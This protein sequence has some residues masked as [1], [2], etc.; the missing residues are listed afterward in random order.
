MAN[1]NLEPGNAT[2][3]DMIAAIDHGI[4]MRTNCSWSIDDSR[5]KFQFG[6]EWGQL[7]AGG[8]LTTVVKNPN[9]RHLATFWRSLKMVGNRDT[10]DIMGTRV[11]QGTESGH[12]HGTCRTGLS[13]RQRR[14]FWWRIDHAGLLLRACRRYHQVTAR[15]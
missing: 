10:V 6:C 2:L 14:G 11:W 15:G 5:N 8:R 9:Y 13:V 12:A 1:I 7:I 4:Y 3:D